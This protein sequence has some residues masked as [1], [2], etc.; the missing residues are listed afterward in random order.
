MKHQISRT[1]ASGPGSHSACHIILKYNSLLPRSDPC[2]LLKIHEAALSQRSYAE[3]IQRLLRFA[4]QT[5]PFAPE[6]HLLS[7]SHNSHDLYLSRNLI[8]FCFSVIFSGFHAPRCSL[9]WEINT[10]NAADCHFFN[11]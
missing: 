11:N 6:L 1:S 2:L 4:L 9:R 10:M 3:L 7:T 5:K 8:Y